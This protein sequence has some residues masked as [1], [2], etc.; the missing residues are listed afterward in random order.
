MHRL[1]VL[2][3]EKL[4]VSNSLPGPT[5]QDSTALT[6]YA[7]CSFRPMVTPPSMLRF[8]QRSAAQVA[9][10][11]FGQPALGD[12]L[13]LRTQRSRCASGSHITDFC[14]ISDRSC[15][16]AAST[17]RPLRDH[18]Q[19]LPLARRQLDLSSGHRPLGVVVADHPSDHRRDVRAAVGNRLDRDRRL[20]EVDVQSV[21]QRASQGV[22]TGRLIRSMKLAF[23]SVLRMR[24]RPF[25]KP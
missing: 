25:A 13:L 2:R 6:G 1:K 14:G 15:A 22:P 10:F 19:H 16:P 5:Y 12:I 4:Y 21:G 9:R 8:L 17:A 24:N 23:T 20:L 3:P 18:P 7:M 11:W